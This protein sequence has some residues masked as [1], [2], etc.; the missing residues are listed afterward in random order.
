MDTSETSES[1]DSTIRDSIN[2]SSSGVDD[3]EFRD[4]VKILRRRRRQ[5]VTESLLMINH[6][7]EDGLELKDEDV[8]AVLD[9]AEKIRASGKMESDGQE[10][11]ELESRFWVALS[12]ISNLVKPATALA[13]RE[14]IDFIESATRSSFSGT[15]N[16]YKV[17]FWITLAIT[18]LMH[19]YYYFIGALLADA[20]GGIQRF[21]AA[22]TAAFT[23]IA[24]QDSS[25]R[26][27]DRE[28]AVNVGNLCDSLD[29][30]RST[31]RLLAAVTFQ[32]GSIRAIEELRDN[33]RH[34][35]ALCKSN[36]STQA[37]E[38]GTEANKDLTSDHLGKL[39]VIDT[40]TQSVN[41]MALKVRDAVGQFILPLLYGMLGAIASIIRDLSTSIREIRY[42]TAFG[43]EYG[44]KVPLGALAG[45]TV[46]LIIAPGSVN[47]AFGL[48]MLG[49]AFG[50]GYSV[51]MFFAALDGIIQ[52]VAQIAGQGSDERRPGGDRRPRDPAA[53]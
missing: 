44:L 42:S 2:K 27:L 37:I 18:L 32:L 29:L 14:R 52:R 16:R 47:T 9:M 40:I 5:A 23:A 17:A 53:G 8:K 38:I 22:R 19:S 6:A 49:L 48:T 11:I 46:G 33:D 21:D 41:A 39:K 30:W 26:S 4:S 36:I 34:Y 25:T 31:N 24:S 43:F 50:F 7:A 51:D 13:I 12:H 10:N 35:S 15:I 1:A 20:T 28:L 45:A 3:E